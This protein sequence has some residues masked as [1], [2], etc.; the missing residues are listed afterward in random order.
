M[1][2]MPRRP[3]GHNSKS[4]N[5]TAPIVSIYDGRQCRGFILARGRL[6]FELFDCDQ[7][8]LGVFP[9]QREAAAAL[10]EARP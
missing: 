2:D 9:T 1:M 5:S 4:K 6:G 7:R 10:D 3:D 8:S